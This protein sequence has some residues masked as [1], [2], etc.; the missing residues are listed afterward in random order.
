[1][2]VVNS[3][4]VTGPHMGRKRPRKGSEVAALATDPPAGEER[5]SL[6]RRKLLSKSTLEVY[7]KHVETVRRDSGLL[8]SASAE[9]I[10]RVTQDS[11][12]NL[13][14][15]NASAAEAGHLYYA[16]RWAHTLT[17]QVMRMSYASLKGFQRARRPPPGDPVSWPS[18]LL[19]A[20][21][22]LE[23]A[24]ASVS[25]FERTVSVVA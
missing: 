11:L 12:V 19:S 13:Y 5:A 7:T 4:T 2:P 16:M 14:L 18:V 1:M 24:P 22:L 25:R 17:N 15:D 20:L 10:D 8:P 3:P 6:L 23:K 21:A 9:E